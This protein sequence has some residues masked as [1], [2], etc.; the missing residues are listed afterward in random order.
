MES[1]M[2]AIQPLIDDRLAE[3]QAVRKL[4]DLHVSAE[5]RAALAQG[6]KEDVV[7]S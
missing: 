3:H 1:A 5:S 4:I 6:L 2:T 7:L